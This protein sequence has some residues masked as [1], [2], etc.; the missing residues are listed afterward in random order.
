MRQRE[1]QECQAVQGQCQSKNGQW[2]LP[3]SS[4]E[5]LSAPESTEGTVI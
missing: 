1:S 3:V 2:S 5:W 4:R